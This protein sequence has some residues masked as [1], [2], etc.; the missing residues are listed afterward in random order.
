MLYLLKSVLSKQISSHF[1]LKTKR[2]DEFYK[3]AYKVVRYHTLKPIK[4]NIPNQLKI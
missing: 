3:T 2:Q 1:R 4:N